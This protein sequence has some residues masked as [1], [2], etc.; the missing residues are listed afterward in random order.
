MAT[1]RFDVSEQSRPTV[2]RVCR[3]V[4]GRVDAEDAWS[5]TFLAAHDAVE[6]GYFTSLNSFED[7][8]RFRSRRRLAAT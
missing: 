7:Q 4:L 8:M 6:R 3:A 1:K 2:L 5:E